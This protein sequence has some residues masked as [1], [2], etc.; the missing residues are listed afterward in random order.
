M[1]ITGPDVVKAVIGEEISHNDLGG[2]ECHATKSGV[3]H[4]VADTDADCIAK[5]KILLS[6]IPDSCTSPLPTVEPTDQP[7]RLCP[8]PG[9]DHPR[10]LQ[11]AATT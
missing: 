1:Y 11:P 2:A 7:D 10:P 6:Y 5:I 8:G 3:C 4:V 9:Q